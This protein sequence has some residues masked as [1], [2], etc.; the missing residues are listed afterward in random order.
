MWCWIISSFLIFAVFDPSLPFIPFSSLPA[1][2][3]VGPTIARSTLAHPWGQDGVFRHKFAC[4]SNMYYRVVADNSVKFVPVDGFFRFYKI[5]ISTK[6]TPKPLWRSLWP[7]AAKGQ[8][9]PPPQK[10]NIFF[11]GGCVNKHFGVWSK[12]WQAKTATIQNGDREVWSKRRQRTKD[13]QMLE[14][15][16]L[17]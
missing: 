4:L 3:E 10:K 13:S 15:L 9:A 16:N 2:S 11:G 6:V 12:R 14:R 5:S 1:P 8:I 7:I 17:E